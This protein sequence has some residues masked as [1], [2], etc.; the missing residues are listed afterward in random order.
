M[1]QGAALL[2][3]LRGSRRHEMEADLVGIKLAGLAGY[4]IRKAP[5]VWEQ[6]AAMEKGRAP[7]PWASTHPS[8]DKR[9]AVLRRELELM[10]QHGLADESAFKKVFATTSYFAL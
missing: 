5:K 3:E 7:P 8:S 9:Q 2:V 1:S 6:M 10:Q 4:D